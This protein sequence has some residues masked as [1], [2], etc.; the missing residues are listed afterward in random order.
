MKSL[1]KSALMY[2][3]VQI[4][5]PSTSHLLNIKITLNTFRA[6]KKKNQKNDEHPH[7]TALFYLTNYL[8]CF[9]LNYH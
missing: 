7:Q 4:Y 8:T 9:C 2:N 1:L 6:V 5:H 3:R